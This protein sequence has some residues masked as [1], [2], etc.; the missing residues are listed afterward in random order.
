[1]ED[2]KIREYHRVTFK[3]HEQELK[4]FLSDLPNATGLLKDLAER[5][6]QERLG[7]IRVVIQRLDENGNPIDNDS[8][9]IIQ[10]LTNQ[11]QALNEELRLVRATQPVIVQG[12]VPQATPL[13]EV[14]VA[15]EEPE[16]I[17]KDEPP[18]PRKR[19][20]NMSLIADNLDKFNKDND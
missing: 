1:M 3:K 18:K 20:R 10:M 11:I 8:N 19:Q 12:I 9:S 17:I 5:E 4:E 7:N 14:A 15:E 13:E 2:K 6:R 16:E